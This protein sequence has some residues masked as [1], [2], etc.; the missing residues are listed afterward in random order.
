MVYTAA[1][2]GRMEISLYRKL[3]LRLL[4]ALPSEDKEALRGILNAFEWI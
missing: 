1:D 2:R 3:I 4:K